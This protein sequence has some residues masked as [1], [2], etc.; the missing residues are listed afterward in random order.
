M[1]DLDRRFHET[2]LG[3]VQPIEG[4]VVSIPVLLEAQCVE[5][6]APTVQEQLR[7][8]CRPS[9]ETDAGPQGHTLSDVPALLHMILGYAPGA[10]HTSAEFPADLVLYVAEGGQTLRPTLA[11]ARAEPEPLR[12]DL[13]SISAAANAGR[14]YEVLLWELP[15]GL[16]LDGNETETGPWDYPPTAKLDRLLRHTRVPI[17]ILCN[18]QQIR[19]LYAPHGESSGH[20]TFDLD[21]MLSVGGRP[22]LDAM[23]MLLSAY[24]VHGV[25]PERALPAILRESRKRQANVTNALSEQ[26]FDAL[27]ILL[28]GFEAAA[29]RDGHG[30]L[31]D[32]LNR[33]DDQLYKGLLT[34]LLRMVFV[35]YA[36]DRGLL[37]VDQP[38]YA[39]N[40]SLLGL[41]ARLQRD[42]GAWP[43]AM[44]RRFSAWGQLIALWR[45]V[46]LGVSHGELHMPPRRG[47]LFDP[48]R[49]A[50]LEG[51]PASSSPPIHNPA[52]QALVRVPTVDD[53]TVFRML[54]KLLVFEGQRLSYR[55]LDVEQIGSIYEGLMGY[56]VARV[57]EPSVCTKPLGVWTHVGEIVSQPTTQRAKWLKDNLGLST[58]Q[59]SRLMAELTAASDAAGQFAALET[60]AVKRDDPTH[61]RARVGQLVLQPGS[62]RRHTSSHYTPRTLSAP[63]VARTLEPLL[64][65]MGDAPTSEAILALKVC[66]PA[67]GSGAFLVEACRYLSE[68]VLAAWTREGKVEA[69]AK[70]HGDPLLYARRRVAQGC[71]YGVDKNLAAVELARLSLWLVTLARDLPFTFVDHAL[72]YGDSLVGLGYEQLR[73]FDW[74]PSGQL[75]L[76]G[77]VVA[78]AVDEALSARQALIDLAQRDLP[79]TTREKEFLLRDADDAILRARAIGDLVVGAFFAHD[80]D[81]ARRQELTRRM[82]RVH[83]WLASDKG[84]PEDLRALAA[85]ARAKVPMF[86]WAIEFPEVFYAGRSD[87]LDGGRSTTPA[88]M[89]AFVGNPPFLG[90][91]QISSQ[92]G[93]AYRDWLLM[94]HPGS[95]GN[96]DLCAHF[97][98]RTYA[99]LGDH[100]TLGLIA[101]NTI[102]Q[103]DTRSTGLQWLVAQGAQIYDATVDLPW[104]GAAAVTVSVVHI[105]VGNPARGVKRALLDGRVARTINSRLNEASERGDA[106]K[107][108]ANAG[109]SFQGSIVLGMGFTLTPDA[110][111][112]LIAKDPRNGERIFAY[113]GGQEVNTSPTQDFD[114][115]VINFGTMSEEEAATWPE[116]FEIVQRLVKPERDNIKRA[117]RR[118]YWWRFGQDT[119]ALYEA[120]RPL[121]R[122][123]VTS[124][125][126]KHLCFSFQPSNRVVSDRLYVFPFEGYTQFAVLQSRVHSVWTWLL[127]S[128]LKTDLNYSATDCFETFAFPQG[129]PRGVVGA[130]EEAGEAL[131]TARA[132]YMVAEGVGLTGTY[133]RLTD[134]QRRDAGV[135]RLRELHEAM[136]RAVCAAY[137]WDDLA[138]TL[139]A[140]G[141]ED[142]RWSAA[143]IDRLFALN[144][145]R[146]AAEAKGKGAKGKGKGKG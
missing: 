34:V 73:A 90:G 22:I 105:A 53:H 50:F 61:A 19:L 47:D 106:V 95:H 107:L 129:D 116:L 51:W 119:P 133:N 54:E 33:D 136:D 87:P 137:G 111:D 67:M 65:A 69:L 125:V 132:A 49:F 58:A 27:Q 72:R 32:A 1:T 18:G 62:E 35:L 48:H 115:Y 8:L 36:E 24:R 127:S 39:E 139:P 78:D 103:G 79:D 110:R 118:K 29:E 85:E 63:V 59:A 134:G 144:G 16:S 3:L 128:T 138:R 141:V 104:A 46:F 131:Y 81:K 120:I 70:A 10:W 11:L 130:L 84:M 109:C 92:F 117:A 100:G 146:A 108:Q 2:W 102:A 45:A 64:A 55:A 12:T 142:P 112:A 42:H 86:H 5:K 89:D 44:S 6:L 66:D 9:R 121:K 71:L 123:L 52:E 143:V 124:R 26:V 114:R 68:Q 75:E 74:A 140:Y 94:A 126:T 76:L 98:R 31:D 96:A 28:R 101:T 135:V 83:A 25:A 56:H 82:D 93:D 23:V 14:G 97:F 77:G 80:K 7:A 13:A 88:C 91:L 17:G 20:L 43:D 122:C 38:L 21:A 57:T 15:A 113:L 40:F 4:L 41:F 30:S 99:L 37:P 145:Q 60:L